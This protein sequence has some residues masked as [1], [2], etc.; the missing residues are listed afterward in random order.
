[1]TQLC[2]CSHMEYMVSDHKPVA[3]I[4]AVQVSLVCLL[5]LLCTRVPVLPTLGVAGPRAPV[6]LMTVV[7]LLPLLEGVSFL[8]GRQFLTPLYCV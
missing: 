4:F 3:A 2:Y 1:M 5:E 8:G 6:L 7:A